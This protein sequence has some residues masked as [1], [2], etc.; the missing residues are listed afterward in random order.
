[1]TTDKAHLL[2]CVLENDTDKP[3]N[4]SVFCFDIVF[5]TGFPQFFFSTLW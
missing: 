1:M 2:K 3:A 4:W 5:K